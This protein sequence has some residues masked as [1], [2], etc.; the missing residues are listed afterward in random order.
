MPYRILLRRDLSQNWNY[1]DPVLMSGEPGYEMDTRKFKMGDG[2]TPWSQLPYYS[3]ITGATG[4]TGAQGATGA[5]GGGSLISVTYSGLTNL[6]DTDGLIQNSSYLITDFKTCYD[7]PDY[8]FNGEEIQTGTYKEGGVSPII[9]LALSSNSLASDAYQPEWPNDDIKYDVSFDQTE[10]TG[11][12]AFGRIT[13]RKD[14]QGNAFDYDFREVLFKRYD[15]YFSETVYDGL[16]SIAPAGGTSS[17]GNIEGNGTFFEN[18]NAGDIIGILKNNTEGSELITYYQIVSIEDNTN[19]VVTG[20]AIS[21]IVNGRLVDAR[22]LL[23]MSWKKNTIISNTNEYEYYTFENHATA[24][25]NVSI[26]TT[27]Y[28]EFREKIFLLPNNVFRNEDL[29]FPNVYTD[30]LFGTDFR[31]NTFND[32]CDS[33]IIRDDFYNNIINSDF[34]HNTINNTF[35]DNIIDCDFNSNTITGSFY[36][37]NFG[38]DDGDEFSFN[39]IDGS[40]YQNFYTGAGDFYYNTIKGSFYNNI[41]LDRF[42][43]NTLTGFYDNLVEDSFYNN[44]IGEQC[45]NN[46]IYS[47]FGENI[48]GIDF[49]DNAIHSGFYENEIGNYFRGNTI[50]DSGNTTNFTFGLN[51][52]GHIFEYNTIRQDFDD[53]QISNSFTY[54]IANGDFEGNVIGNDFYQNVN[55]GYAFRDNHIGNNFNNNELI[56]D[57]F[58]NNHI[59]NDFYSNSISYNFKNNQ[60]GSTFENNNLGNDDYF[61]WDNTGIENLDSRD[62]D[63]FYNALYGDDGEAV[64]NVILGKELIMHDTVNN[65]YHKVKFTQWTQNGNG[66]GFS[67]ERTKVW[68]TEEPTVYFTKKNYEDIVDVIVEGSLEIARSNNGGAIYNIADENNWNSNVSPVGTE[69]NS[70]YTQDNN[71]GS[72]FRDNIIAG[73][74]KGNLI[75][76]IFAGNNVGPYIDSNQFFGPV[77]SNQIGTV[78]T[79]NDFLG[80]VSGNKWISD[81]DS[82]VIGLNFSNNTFGGGVYNNT[83]ADDFQNNEIGNGFQDNLIGDGFGFGNNDPQGNKIGNNFQDNIISEYFYNNSIPDNFNNNTIGDYFQWNIINTAIGSTD[84]TTNYGNITGFSYTAGGTSASD[85]LYVGLTATTDGKGTGATFEVLVTSGIVTEVNEDNQG[86]LYQIGDTLTILGTAIGGVTGVIDLFTSDAIGKTGENGNYDNVFAGGTGGG[87]NAS[88]N[89][90]VTSSQV[91]AIDLNTGGGGYKNGDLLVISGDVFGGTSG[92]DDITIEVTALYSDDITIG[93][94]GVSPNPS[95]YEP[96]TCQI[97]EKKQLAEGTNKKL[98]FYDGNGILTITDIND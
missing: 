40:F 93:V 49:Y 80:M 57:Y 19:M 14:D 39:T 76:D 56:G 81:F 13:Y 7:Q 15:A 29:E 51:R 18:F 63:N 85:D 17:N 12:P 96:Y 70:I 3:G 22:V 60:I 53:N 41:I 28:T 10:V 54:N 2:Q 45:Y 67:Y 27:S 26:N 42:S 84:F 72:N 48:I 65:Q 52:I 92:S 95:V 61:N 43:K 66:S 82:N 24:F 68:P 71:N 31:N 97:F 35:R 16:V 86:K 23:G 55:I 25:N 5:P 88:F 9:V 62:Y 64:G 37:N 34:D 91:S 8:N 79:G 4:A 83:I 1:N 77:Y 89:I 33:N 30:N 78:T 94:T 58:Q 50:G 74:F 47:P 32:D 20:K 98:S 59:G 90:T 87:E 36:E 44:Q 46:R 75:F 38:D 11:G 6:I 73:L 21:E 69:W